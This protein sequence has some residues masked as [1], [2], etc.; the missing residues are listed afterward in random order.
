[1]S[2]LL[3]L[4]RWR[5]TVVVAVVLVAVVITGLVLV[6]SGPSHSSPV[7][8]PADGRG[9]ATLVVASGTPELSVQTANLGS[10]LVRASVPAGAT[11]RP[12]LD[13]NGVIR[14]TLVSGSG[15]NGKYTLQVLLSDAVTWTIDFDGGTDRTVANLRGGKIAAVTFGAGSDIIDLALPRPSGTPVIRLDGGASQFLLTLPPGVPAQVTAAAGAAELTLD[16]T[17]RTGVAGGTVLTGPGWAGAANRFD[18]DAASGVDQL[19]VSRW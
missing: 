17:T 11:V 8:L 4:E 19:S 12:L 2:G 13:Q 10:T 7:A 5:L 3:W 18:I 15:H 6:F 14:L 9:S 16:S 1:M